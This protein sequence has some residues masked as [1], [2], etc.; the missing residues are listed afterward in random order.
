MLKPTKAHCTRNTNVSIL[1]EHGKF[2]GK[3]LDGYMSITN[4]GDDTGILDNMEAA[5]VSTLEIL[6]GAQ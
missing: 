6:L 4:G 1:N 2:V 5:C 3:V